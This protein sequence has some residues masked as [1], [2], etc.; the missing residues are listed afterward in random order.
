MGFCLTPLIP[1]PSPPTCLGAY[2]LHSGFLDPVAMPTSPQRQTRLCSHGGC[3]TAYLSLS[4]PQEHRLRWN[5]FA[6][7]SG[8]AESGHDTMM[9]FLYL[10]TYLPFPGL[11]F[12]I[13]SSY[14]VV[15]SASR[16][17][18]VGLLARA[19]PVVVSSVAFVHLDMTSFSLVIEGQFCQVWNSRLTVFSP[20]T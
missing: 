15:P 12:C 4:R 1:H 20:N 10:C 9:Q 14:G 18:S 2:Q 11:L 7:K 5:A 16:S 13:N 8:R 17:I 6:F 19:E 3:H